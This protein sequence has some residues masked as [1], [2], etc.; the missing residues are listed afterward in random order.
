AKRQSAMCGGQSVHVVDLTVRSAP[1]V[2]G[3]SIPTGDTGLG[4][5]WLRVRRNREDISFLVGHF[6]RR[7]RLPRYGPNFRLRCG[8]G[9]GRWW[10]NRYFGLL[11]SAASSQNR[12]SND[13][14][15]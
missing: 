10:G 13:N 7:L 9:D 15:E 4:T 8:F 6:R 5:N 2:V 12:Y 1:V 3:R 14:T 11:M